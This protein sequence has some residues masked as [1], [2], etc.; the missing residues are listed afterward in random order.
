MEKAK[1][2][3]NE[4]KKTHFFARVGLAANLSRGHA[5]Q[6]ML[7]ERVAYLSV[8]KFLQFLVTDEQGVDIV[9][10]Q[11]VAAVLQLVVVNHRDERVQL[12]CPD[13]AG[14]VVDGVNLQ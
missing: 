4:E 3:C 2:N 12:R 10:I 9:V 5:H 1:N 8:G 6:R 13:V 7:V 11:R 14:V